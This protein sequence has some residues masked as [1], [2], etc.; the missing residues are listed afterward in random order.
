MIMSKASDEQ[1]ALVQ[2]CNELKKKVALLQQQLDS[3][4]E[5]EARFV[6]M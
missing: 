1:H 6:E 4:R 2:E 5:G 3:V